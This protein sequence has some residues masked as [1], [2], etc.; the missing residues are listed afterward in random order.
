MAGVSTHPGKFGFVTL[1][2]LLTAG[3]EGPVFA[4]NRDGAEV[5]GIAVGGRVDE[6]PDGEAD[7]VVRLH[8]GVGQRRPPAGRAPKGVRAAFITSAGYGE[9]GEEGP[10]AQA[11]LVDLADELGMLLAGPN[12]QG[13]VS[14]AGRSSAPRSWLPSR[15]RG[16]SG[17]PASRATSC[18]AF[19]NLAASP[20]SAS[21]VPCRRATPPLSP[22]PT[23]STT[24]PTTPRPRSASPTSR[25]SADGRAFF[26][27]LPGGRRAQAARPA[28]GRR[29]RGRAASR[30]QPHR[31]PRER[32]PRLRRRVPPGRRHPGRTSRRPSRLA[33]TFATQPLPD[34]QPGRGPHH[35]RRLGRRDRRRHQPAPSSSCPPAGRPAGRHR[36]QAAAPLEPQQS[37]R[38]RGGETRD[39]IPEVLHLVASPSRR[40]RGDLPRPRH[41]VE[42]G[43]LMRDRPFLSRSRP[44]AHRRLPRAPGRPLRRGGR[45]G[46]RRHRQADP[47]PPSS[48][49]PSPDNA[50][51]PAV[52]AIGRLCYPSANRAVVALDH[53]WRRSRWLSRHAG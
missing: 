44:R 8:P 21:V 22:C 17:S 12:G 35:R 38:P 4:T 26:E 7:L 43:Q 20:A 11:E 24:S 40:R 46:Q 52:R 14:H 31:L 6:L 18:R 29:H 10:A 53:L 16:A 19:Q 49:P 3:Y 2:N 36:R 51:P 5:L 48:P 28:E 41:P 33:A 25:G 50:G 30:G 1:H 32:R 13:V 34:G 45:R 23:I 47:S 42:P 39:T 15:P 27:R 37:Y 9:A